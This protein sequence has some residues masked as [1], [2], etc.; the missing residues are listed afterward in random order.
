[1]EVEMDRIGL[2]NDCVV[3]SC[4]NTSFYIAYET[5]FGPV[6]PDFGCWSA[7]ADV[8]YVIDVELYR[9]LISIID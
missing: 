6:P 1:V 9:L 3:G 5:M 7:Y 2:G 4:A 8:Y